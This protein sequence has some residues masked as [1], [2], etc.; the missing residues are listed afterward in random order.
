MRSVFARPSHACNRSYKAL[1]C[2]RAI[3]RDFAA[4]RLLTIGWADQS[5]NVYIMS[6]LS[7]TLYTAVTNDLVRRVF[8]HNE[9]KPGSFTA[10]YGVNR[11]V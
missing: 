9:G 1:G 4:G 11:L 8:E 2:K 5:D 7:R 3:A 10:R 6:S